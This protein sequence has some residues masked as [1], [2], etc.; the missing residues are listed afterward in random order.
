MNPRVVKPNCSTTQ[1]F[2][3]FLILFL[4]KND[5]SKIHYQY[6]HWLKRLWTLQFKLLFVIYGPRVSLIWSSKHWIRVKKR[7]IISILTV[8]NNPMKH[9]VCPVYHK[10]LPW[11]FAL[12]PFQ[13]YKHTKLCFQ[14]KMTEYVFMEEIS[15]TSLWH[16]SSPRPQEMKKLSSYVPWDLW[17]ILHLV[18]FRCPNIHL[19]VP[20]TTSPGIT[21]CPYL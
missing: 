14:S 12:K 6:Y 16:S 9:T 20:G 21:C 1:G 2:I 18:I 3:L 19:Y 5:S 15:S 17:D 7:S 10:L 4:I 11:T 8:R 13:T